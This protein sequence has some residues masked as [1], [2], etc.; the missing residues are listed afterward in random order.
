MASQFTTAARIKAHLGIPASVTQHDAKIGYAVD[1]VDSLVL[2]LLGLD[3]LTGSVTVQWYTDRIDVPDSYEDRVALNHYPVVQ[4]AAVTDDGSLVAATDY[5]TRT[6]VGEIVLSGSASF[7]TTGKQMVVVT[8]QAGF[9]T[10]PGALS[11]VGDAM[12]AWVFNQLPKAG[13]ASEK[14]GDYQYDA[15][16]TAV[17]ES[18]LP[19]LV[20]RLL[21]GF[22]R[23]GTRD[24]N[25]SG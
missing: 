17:A 12:G 2:P 3:P 4:V 20:R 8:Y 18:D 16:P 5:Y 6:D 22:R 15:V 9:A 13:F 19:P 11:L 14:V 23:A 25:R 21:A 10:V 24:T 1:A 7:W